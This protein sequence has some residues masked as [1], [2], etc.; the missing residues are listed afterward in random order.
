MNAQTLRGLLESAKSGDQE[1]FE[2]IMNA[3]GNLVFS[4][5]FHTTGSRSIAL[6]VCQETWIRVWKALP[7]F[8]P[9]GHFAVWLD[10][11]TR[12]VATDHLRK[13]KAYANLVRDAALQ[14]PGF[15]AYSSQ[16]REQAERAEAVVRKL[17]R[18]LP[19][20]FRT[21]VVLFELQGRSITEVSEM[22]GEKE[23]TIRVWLH[24]A[25]TKMKRLLE[26]MEVTE[27]DEGLSE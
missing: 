16:R 9:R 18:A 8:Q 15:S 19:A 27:D 14:D 1:A 20:H 2:E 23:G 4:I 13:R 11:I 17:L 25:R 7:E 21:A 5:A 26:G 12:N 10:R 24:R 6:D 3:F 22:L